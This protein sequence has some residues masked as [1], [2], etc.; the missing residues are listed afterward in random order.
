[1]KNPA[2]TFKETAAECRTAAQ[3]LDLALLDVDPKEEVDFLEDPVLLPAAGV[4][5]MLTHLEESIL[6][7]L[8]G[9]LASR[10]NEFVQDRRDKI[11]QLLQFGESGKRRKL[12]RAK[13]L[14]EYEE[15]ARRL[16]QAASHLDAISA[17]L[18]AETPARGSRGT[19]NH[20]SGPVITNSKVGGL[21]IGSKAKGSGAVEGA[22]KPRGSRR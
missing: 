22:K 19:Q 20:F 18:S 13:Q 11:E 2:V 14:A 9:L 15:Q 21:A 6:H 10:P 1:M 17:H 5:D 12:S 3:E 16:R 4:I 7:Q 8:D